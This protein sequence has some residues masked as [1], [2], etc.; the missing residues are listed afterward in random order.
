MQMKP[1]VQKKGSHALTKVSVG[2]SSFDFSYGFFFGWWI[3]C[4]WPVALILLMKTNGC[5]WLQSYLLTHIRNTSHCL[6]RML[7]KRK[8]SLCECASARFFFCLDSFYLCCFH[9]DLFLYLFFHARSSEE[10]MRR[11][12]FW[13]QRI[14]RFTHSLS[15]GKANN[16]NKESYF[17]QSNLCYCLKLS[18]T[19]SFPLI[20]SLDFYWVPWCRR[21]RPPW[22]SWPVQ[23]TTVTRLA[24]ASRCRCRNRSWSRSRSVGG[25]EEKERSLAWREDRKTMKIWIFLIYEIWFV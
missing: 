19:K 20:V 23:R 14:F 2:R 6:T 17:S 16:L 10:H 12:S 3:L 11:I 15:F 13:A 8:Y 5:D 24:E 21:L 9:I 22:T 4:L 7:W 18:N 1:A 25:G